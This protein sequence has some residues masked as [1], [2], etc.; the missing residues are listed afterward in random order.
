M[1][2]K[3]QSLGP[4]L[5]FAEKNEAVAWILFQDLVHECGPVFGRPGS[6]FAR[7]AELYGN[8]FTG[9]IAPA[10]TQIVRVCLE[11]KETLRGNRSVSLICRVAEMNLKRGQKLRGQNVGEVNVLIDVALNDRLHVV[12]P[13]VDTAK[14]RVF[15]A[16]I[17]HL[18]RAGSKPVR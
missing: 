10:P 3:G 18:T 17:T 8:P 12:A 15:A 2:E 4:I 6:V 16:G 13:A 9:K 14:T 11:S 5:G 7:G 1:G